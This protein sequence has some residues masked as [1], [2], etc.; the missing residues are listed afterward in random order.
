MPVNEFFHFS[1]V[2]MVAI[3]E[4]RERMKNEEE[5]TS[6]LE[7]ETIKNAKEH[8]KALIEEISK[9]IIKIESEEKKQ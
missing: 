6:A 9:D 4:E 1:K 3:S 7:R 5:L 2:Y 8:L